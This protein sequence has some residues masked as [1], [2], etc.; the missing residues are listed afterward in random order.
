MTQL[1]A[2]INNLLY[3]SDDDLSY[4]TWYLEALVSYKHPTRQ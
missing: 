4:A 1:C 3:F 2:E